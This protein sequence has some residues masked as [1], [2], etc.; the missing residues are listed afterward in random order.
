MTNKCG[1]CGKI[2]NINEPWVYGKY[3]GLPKSS[4]LFWHVEC[5]NRATWNFNINPENMLK[6]EV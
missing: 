4:K 2:I 6:F 1:L 3:P 5:Y